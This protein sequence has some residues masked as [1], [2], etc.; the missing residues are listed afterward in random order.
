MEKQRLLELHTQRGTRIIGSEA[1][2]KTFDTVV[3]ECR[4]WL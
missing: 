4:C 3:N 1:N 2:I